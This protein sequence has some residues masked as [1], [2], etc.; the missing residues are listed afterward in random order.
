MSREMSA[1][2]PGS[3]NV[4][5]IDNP[6]DPGR[7]FVEGARRKLFEA[8]AALQKSPLHKATG[9]LD[10]GL[11]EIDVLA[12]YARALRIA[13]TATAGEPAAADEPALV[14]H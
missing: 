10:G 8:R 4:V 12:D 13:P 14:S 5:M 3:N 1:E 11:G 2:S 7:L 9:P 6:P